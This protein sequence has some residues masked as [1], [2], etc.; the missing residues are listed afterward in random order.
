MS[1]ET[2]DEAAYRALDADA[3]E[4]RKAEI[5]ALAEDPGTDAETVGELDG[6][7]RRCAAEIGRRNRMAEFRKVEMSEVRSGAGSV[8]DASPKAETRSASGRAG[9]LDSPEYRKAFMD[10]IQRGVPIPRELR[11]DTTAADNEPEIPITMGR[12]IIKEMSSYGTIWNKVRKLSVKG[13]L[14]FRVLDLQPTATWIDETAVS[15]EQAA[16]ATTKV[17]FSFYQLECRMSQTLLASAV[18]FDDFQ[19]LFVPAVAEA[20]VRALEDAI[21]NGDGTSQ[22]LGILNDER[23][24]NVVYMSET[25]F[26]DWTQWRKKVKAAIPISY[27]KGEFTMA[28]STFDSYIETMADDS[29]APVSIGYNPVTGEEQQRLMGRNVTTVETDI[30]PDF[31]TASDGD[32]VAI[33]GNWADYAV[34]TQPGMP[35]TTK[36]WVNDEENKEK[37]KALMAIDGKVLDN[38]GFLLV[39]K[40]TEA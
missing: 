21:V 7:S 27:R 26:A 24:T 25:E 37:I 18:T 9:R 33:Y 11:S 5:L 40:G 2:M 30:L 13:G 1:F 10:Y 19:A 39:K 17:S 12:E 36:R 32:V 31:D 20:M 38:H 14:W 29:N 15:E 23:I 6:E 8:L 22:P 3:L 28:Q 34:N 16:D 4:Q 35:L